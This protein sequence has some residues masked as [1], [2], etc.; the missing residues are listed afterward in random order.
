MPASTGRGQ[1]AWCSV[2]RSPTLHVEVIN[3]VASPPGGPGSPA[4]TTG[5]GLIGMRERVAAAG[6]TIT[7]TTGAVFHIRIDLPLER[8]T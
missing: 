4:Q 1:R 6:G 7:V 3:P 5:H 8:V 2:G